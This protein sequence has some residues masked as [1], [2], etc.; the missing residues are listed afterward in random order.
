MFLADYHMHTDYSS[1]STTTLEEAAIRARIQGIKEIAITDH[2]E[3][4]GRDALFTEYEPDRQRIELAA[5]RKRFKNDLVILQGVEIGQPHRYPEAVGRLLAGGDFDFVLGSVH[6]TSWDE[7]M[8]EQDYT[9]D[10]IDAVIRDY[11]SEVKAM[12][13]SGRF[14]CVAHIDLYNRY[15]AAK[16]LYISPGA[17][18]D[19]Y[20]EIFRILARCGKGIEVNTSGLRRRHRSTMPEISLLK[21]FKEMGGEYVTAGSD[22]HHRDHVGNHIATAF[23]MIREAGFEYIT[24]Y[25]KRQPVMVPITGACYYPSIAN[26]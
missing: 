26:L 21:L 11:L 7:D 19:E 6:R 17:Y 2:Y 8:S 10:T 25:R 4:T 18:L 12:A 23:N 16:G 20:R 22:A 24:T 1:D 3:L 9:A 5:L 14:D 15:A 13:R